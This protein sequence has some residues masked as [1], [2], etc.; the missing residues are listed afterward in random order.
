MISRYY[1]KFI[2]VHIILAVC[3]VLSSNLHDYNTLMFAMLGIAEI[4]IDRL[5]RVFSR[6]QGASNLAVRSYSTFDSVVKVTVDNP[7]S[8]SHVGPGRHVYVQDPSISYQW[9]PF[10]VSSIDDQNKRL[11]FHIK[12]RGD[13]TNNVVSKLRLNQEDQAQQCGQSNIQIEGMYGSNLNPLYDQSTSCIFV[14]GGIGITGIS[15]AVQSCTE[16]GI[17]C[18]VV[19]LVHSIA[20]METVGKDILWNSRLLD[21]VATSNTKPTFQVF[22]TDDEEGPSTNSVDISVSNDSDDQSQTTAVHE[23]T[24]SSDV[25]LSALVV[26]SV[27]LVCIWLGFLLSRQLCCYRHSPEIDSAKL[28][29]LASSSNSC[30]ICSVDDIDAHQDSPEDELPCCKVSDCYL[31]FRALP[32]VMILFVAPSIAYILLFILRKYR[33]R[34]HYHSAI[35]EL[36]TITEDQIDDSS[37]IRMRETDHFVSEGIPHV[38]ASDLISINYQRPDISAVVQKLLNTHDD[39]AFSSCTSIVVCGPQ[40][41]LDDV[42]QTVKRQQHSDNEYRLIVL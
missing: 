2:I 25:K 20:E 11:S 38:K 19:W 39:I 27:V 42:S 22:V 37:D 5:M 33:S 24:I 16:Q 15:E 12:A 4:I 18:S 23:E 8:S 30:Q 35:Q 28:C 26:S 6:R 40:S 31:C 7:A 32:V 36:T 14:A 41:L 17:P 10:S 1:D 9:H 21:S 3:F 13:W 34:Y 29:G